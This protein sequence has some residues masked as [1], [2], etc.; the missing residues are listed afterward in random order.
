MSY[1]KA[2]TGPA[3]HGP[4]S[5]KEKEADRPAAQP[6]GRARS[7]FSAQPGQRPLT[8]PGAEPAASLQAGSVRPTRC[9]LCG[10]G[11]ADEAGLYHCQEGCHT[12]W[13][14]ETTGQL[15]DLAGL[16]F[17][18]CGCCQPPQAL[19]RGEQ[20]ILCPVSGEAYLLLSAGPAPLAQAAPHGLCQCCQPSMPLLRQEEQLVCQAKPFNRYEQDDQQLILISPPPLR[21][22]D[23]WTAIDDAL[24]QNTARLTVNGLFDLE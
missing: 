10:H 6:A 21:Q 22:D 14:V 7:H 18:V 3:V 4:S 20:H 17:G 16:P 2:T 11:L 1:F 12:R 23:V 24:R 15:V 19:I 13:L 5:T 9:P 8:P